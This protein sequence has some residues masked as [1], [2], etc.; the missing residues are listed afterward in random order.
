MKKAKADLLTTGYSGV[1]IY[2]RTSVC[3][4]IRAEQGIT[5]ILRPPK[6]ETSFFDLPEDQQIG[7]YPKV[8]QYLDTPFDA[9]AIDSEGRAVILEFPAFVLIGTY[10]P[11]DSMGD[12]TEFRMGFLNLLDARIR[13][14]TAMGKRV[15]L[16]GDLNIMRGAQDCAELSERLRKEGLTMDEFFSRPPRRLFNQLLEGGWVQGDRDEGREKPVLVDLCRE[17]HPD[18]KGMYTHWEVKK[19]YRP[20]NF[21]SRID[22][23]CAST[24][25]KDWF[26][27][28]NIQEGLQGSDHC[29]VY[30]ILKDK[31][32]L[33]GVEANISD[34]MNPPGMFVEGKRRREWVLKDLLPTS[35]KMLPEFQNRRSIKDMF[36]RPAL[37][38]KQSTTAT[39]RDEDASGTSIDGADASTP[40]DTQPSSTPKEAGAKQMSRAPSPSPNGAPAKR[41]ASQA[42]P[43]PTKKSKVTVAGKTAKIGPEKGQMGLAGFFKPKR[44]SP[45]PDNASKNDSSKISLS[46]GSTDG[47]EA[48]Q[49]SF[50]SEILSSRD[51][52]G[53][54]RPTSATFTPLKEIAPATTSAPFNLDDQPDVVDP[55]V[56]K[57][58]WSKLLGGRVV[59][60][61]EHGEP[62]KSFQTKKK[63]TNCGRNFYIC[64][65]PLGPKGEKETR[66]SEWRCGTFIWSSDWKGEKAEPA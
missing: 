17:F 11:A 6:S 19:N 34:I 13:N 51:G 20:A 33:D 15:I 12:K 65:R 43:K 50:E 64:A 44:Q 24:S 48:D 62:C 4:P 49:Q 55:I 36:S 37:P 16:T 3:A 22:Y 29:P 38:K 30:A 2:I 45:V 56:A 5:G 58:S 61:C 23:I 32:L 21:G 39:V 41:P 7:G 9:A 57:E 31:V 60:K 47:N 27:E 14:L 54:A 46:N 1:A 53:E 42:L 18:R 28:V 40:N 52:T 25:M 10:C 59:P 66:D 26:S 35:A 63:G 8:S